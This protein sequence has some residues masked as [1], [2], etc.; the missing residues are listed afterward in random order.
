MKSREERFLSLPFFPTSSLTASPSP[1]KVFAQSGSA[2]CGNTLRSHDPKWSLVAMP[3][4]LRAGAAYDLQTSSCR[5]SYV[6]PTVLVPTM[7]LDA[8]DHLLLYYIVSWH[9]PHHQMELVI[10]PNLFANL[11]SSLSGL[12]P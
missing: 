5:L 10:P 3:G 12:P 8:A 11:C 9:S 7:L 1:L 2:Q 4:A 6:P